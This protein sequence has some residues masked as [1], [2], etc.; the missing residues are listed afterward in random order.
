MDAP[1]LMSVSN[2]IFQLRPD[3]LRAIVKCVQAKQRISFDFVRAPGKDPERRVVDPWGVVS[4]NNRAYFVGY[5]IDRD[6]VRVFRLKKVSKLKKVRHSD[7]FHERAGDLQA[8]VEE[9][10]R[11]E[12]I[13]AT[14]TVTHG[15]GE[16]L[17]QRGTRASK[18]GTG[19]ET[20]TDTDTITLRGVD[21]DWAVR[22][23]ASLA[24]SVVA[25]EPSEVSED[26]VKLLRTALEG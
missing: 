3:T 25:V 17:A 12:L 13:D 14:V 16:E 15:V 18:V 11:G 24:G 5:D 4:L 26:V 9:T 2:D 21:R 23:I 6:D 19:G 1:A 7:A 20:D 8:L 22:T 10:L